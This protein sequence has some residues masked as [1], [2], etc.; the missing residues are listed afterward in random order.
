M[1]RTETLPPLCQAPEKI[2]TLPLSICLTWHVVYIQYR[3]HINLRNTSLVVI[4]YFTVYIFLDFT[5]TLYLSPVLSLFHGNNRYLSFAYDASFI[6]QAVGK[7]GQNKPR[8]TGL[9]R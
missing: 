6:V 7:I 2:L 4:L 9:Y 8:H 5:S 1:K 3:L